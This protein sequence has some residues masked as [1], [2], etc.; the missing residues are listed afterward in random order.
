MRAGGSVFV[1]VLI[2]VEG[3]VVHII[4]CFSLLHFRVFGCLFLRFR[5]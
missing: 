2:D 1:G 4:T 5:V 3:V